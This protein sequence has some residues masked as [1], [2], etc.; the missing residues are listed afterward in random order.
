MTQSYQPPLIVRLIA[1]FFCLDAL[2]AVCLSFLLDKS[3]FA[4]IFIAF[5]NAPFFIIG[6]WLQKGL[7]V[8]TKDS[9][10]YD[11]VAYDKIDKA[12]PGLS[13]EGAALMIGLFWLIYAFVSNPISLPGNI[14]VYDEHTIFGA[15]SALFLLDEIGRYVFGFFT[16]IFFTTLVVGIFKVILGRWSKKRTMVSLNS[17]WFLLLAYGV[18]W[19]IDHRFLMEKYYWIF[20]LFAFRLLAYGFAVIYL[21]YRNFHILFSMSTSE[22]KVL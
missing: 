4:T 22:K 15:I 13:F 17:L 19:N 11:I 12:D 9:E 8:K 2:I 16:V 1:I 21:A 3:L 14:P 10:G 6:I 18:I 5:L 7:T 20:I